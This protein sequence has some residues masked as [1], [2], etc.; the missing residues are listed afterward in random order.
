[1]LAR[2]RNRNPGRSLAAMLVYDIAWSIS[3]LIA[4]G[5]YRLRVRGRHHVPPTG[6]LLIIANHQSLFDPPAI[7]ISI[8]CRHINFIARAGLFKFRP[9]GVLI[10]ALN[11]VPIKES[12][13]DTAAIRTALEQLARGRAVII[14]P[15]G[16]R[17]EDG[18]IAEFKRGAWVLMSRAKCPVLPAAIEGAFDAWPRGAGRPRFWGRRL[19]VEFGPVIPYEVLAPMGSQ[20]G[21]SFL[22]QTVDAMRLD[23]RHELRNVTDDRYPA[24]GPGDAG[25]VVAGSAGT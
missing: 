2:L 12:G 10:E 22:R 24:P 18:A 4:T 3:W 17:T 9:F 1:M 25:P 5:I 19:A 13:S 14:F 16:S 21:L 8:A 20:A 6:P 7:A 11:A 15:E 23:L